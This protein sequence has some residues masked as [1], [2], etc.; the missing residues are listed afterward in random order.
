MVVERDVLREVDTQ[1]L[2]GESLQKVPVL[3]IKIR[4]Q[5]G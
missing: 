1:S 2:L 4:P 3:V 5:V